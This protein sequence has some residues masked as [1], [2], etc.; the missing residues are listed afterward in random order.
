M[1][2]PHLLLEGY[3]APKEKLQDLGLLGDILDRFPEKL[4][5]TKIMPPYVF[6][7]NGGEVKDDWGISGIVL[8]AESHIAIHTFPEK[9][10]FT[11]DI[12]SCKDFDIRDAVNFV[13]DELQPKYFDETLV[14]RGREFPRSIGRAAKV[15][16]QERL[17]LASMRR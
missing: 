10:F 4:T 14:T 2:G 11:L 15:M 12:F 1:F 5:M 6:K 16:N 8:I 13:V 3:G 17:R 9:G 7:Y